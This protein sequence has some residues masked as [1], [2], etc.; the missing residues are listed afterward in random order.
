MTFRYDRAYTGALQACIFDWAGTTVDFG[1]VAPAVTFVEV[2]KRRDVP[3]TLDE[4]RGPMG[5][6]KRVHIQEITEMGVVRQR[7]QDQ[8]GRLPDDNDVEAMYQEFIPLQLDCLSIY[9]D[10]IP[11]TLDVV[12][13]LR[14]RGM[15]IGT[16]TGYTAEMTAINVK[17]AKRQGY[18]PDSIVSSDQ[19]PLG[20]PFP[21]MCLQ[22]VLNLGVGCVQACVKVDDTVTGIEEGLNAGMWTIGLSVSGNEV[23][24]SLAD[25]QACAAG[26]Q[27]RLRARAE[28]KLRRSGAHY[29]ADT[30]ADLIPCM[31][32]IQARVAGGEKP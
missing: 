17:D 25:W 24:L 20:R 15:K 31:D 11:G 27:T 4:A 19:L 16:T 21:H 8:H 3:I 28:D 30:I 26:D 32:D 12:G 14:R 1:C 5:A 18:E 2:F 13:E 29:V 10:L 23:G 9:S 7:W 22:N 6:H